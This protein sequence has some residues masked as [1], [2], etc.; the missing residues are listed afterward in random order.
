MVGGAS[1]LGCSRV[2]LRA[3]ATSESEKSE[4]APLVRLSEEN[5]QTTAS[6]LGGV[7]GLLV[8]G[9]WVGAALFAA[10]TYLTRREEDDIS[11][12][13]KGVARTGLEAI[14]SVGDLN[15]QYKVSDQVGNSLSAAVQSAKENPSTK[16]AATAVSGA[17]E[18]AVDSVSKFDKEVDIKGTAGS[19]LTSASNTTYDA[20]EKVAD[21]NKEYKVTDAVGKKLDE[22]NKEY[23]ISD[24]IGKI[25]DQVSSSVQGSSKAK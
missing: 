15:E 20:V 2:I 13:L 24:Q 16:D 19:L 22:V 6:L 18:K 12:A 1:Q 23:K 8:G 10:T 4:K 9:V 3:E 17:V 25:T 21:L 5:V 14:N 7:L 11:K